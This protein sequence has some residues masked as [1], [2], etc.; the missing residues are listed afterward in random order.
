MEYFCKILIIKQLMGW[1]G[2]N[3]FIINCFSRFPIPLQQHFY[4]RASCYVAPRAVLSNPEIFK[5]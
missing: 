4:C 3:Y 2:Y 5:S 1:G